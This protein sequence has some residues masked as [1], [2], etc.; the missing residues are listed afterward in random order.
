MRVFTVIYCVTDPVPPDVLSPEPAAAEGRM[1]LP[2]GN[3]LFEKKEDIPVLC[4]QIPVQPAGLII[5]IVRIIVSPLGVHKFIAGAEHGCAVGQEEHT[6]EIL[7]LLLSQSHHPRW[8]VEVALP[9]AV[10]TQVII[11]SI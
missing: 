11:G 8:N 7:N 10:P 9:P 5:L 3:H 2:E 4:E 1:V 6:T